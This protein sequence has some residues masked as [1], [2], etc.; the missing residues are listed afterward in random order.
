[1]SLSANWQQDVLDFHKKFGSFTGESPSIPPDKVIDLRRILI[2]EEVGETL[3]AMKA[4]D[5][6]GVADG[7]VDCIVVLLGTA[8]AYGID[9][10]PLW[11]EIHRT[12]MAKENG[13]IREDGKVLKPVG[14]IPPDIKGLLEKQKHTL[15]K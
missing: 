15:L 10:Q 8:N 9:I 6:V 5:L 12:N 7:V 4:D 3:A 13:G 1:M 11:D 14:W 2:R